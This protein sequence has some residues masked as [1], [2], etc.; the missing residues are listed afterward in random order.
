MTPAR[1]NLALFAAAAA[2]LAAALPWSAVVLG[3]RERRSGASAEAALDR[4][5]ARERAASPGG[6]V[7]FGPGPGEREAALPG[8]A[9]GAADADFAFDAVP[10]P[11]GALRL[12]AV[13]RPEAVAAGRVVPLLRA[14]VLARGAELGHEGPDADPSGPAAATR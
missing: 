1:A 9:L 3:P 13:S 2:L 11:G 5:A 4:I 10:D 6:P 7:A 12:R 8:L 14:R